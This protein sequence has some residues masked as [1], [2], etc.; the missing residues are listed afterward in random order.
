MEKAPWHGGPIRPFR[1]VDSFDLFA[2]GVYWPEGR[3]PILPFF[4]HSIIPSFHLSKTRI[5]GLVC[6]L[7]KTCG[8]SYTI[9]AI[10]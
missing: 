1:F 9:S 6:F 8:N 5:T 7:L 10:E 3:H 4:Q 2:A